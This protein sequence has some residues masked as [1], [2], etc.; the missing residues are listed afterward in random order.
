MKNTYIKD[1]IKKTNLDSGIEISYLI[2]LQNDEKEWNDENKKCLIN[3]YNSE[4]KYYC[5]ENLDKYDYNYYHCLIINKKIIIYEEEYDSY[6]CLYLNGGGYNDCGKELDYVSNVSF[7]DKMINPYNLQVYYLISQ[8]FYSSEIIDVLNKN[9]VLTKIK[10][11]NTEVI[12]IDMMEINNLFE[13]IKEENNVYKIICIIKHSEIQ[14]KFEV[15]DLIYLDG[16]MISFYTKNNGE[17]NNIS[18]LPTE[19][20]EKEKILFCDYTIE[21][22]MSELLDL[23][24]SKNIHNENY[25]KVKSVIDSIL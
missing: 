24:N 8:D 5:K 13:V 16:S 6:S 11:I 23:I 3:V 22:K 21:R 1:L 20:I 14:N 10:N 25:E 19:I 15:G 9:D 2:I 12:N 18:C 7:A 17:I 4:N